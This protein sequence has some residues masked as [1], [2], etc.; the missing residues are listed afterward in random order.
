VH[1]SVVFSP[2]SSRVAYAAERQGKFLMVVDGK[3]GR[4][5]DDIYNPV[6]SPDSRH[7]AYVGGQV[8]SRSALV[9]GEVV[10]RALPLASNSTAGHKIG[11]SFLPCRVQRPGK[12]LPPE[13]GGRNQLAIR[14]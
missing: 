9:D 13:T 6:F 8:G 11:C 5:F 12:G 14:H 3:E 1:G 7:V 10:G 2:N 4:L